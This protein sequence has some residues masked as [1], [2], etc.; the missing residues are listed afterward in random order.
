M[1]T[2][3]EHLLKHVPFTEVEH[4]VDAMAA[5]SEIE[6]RLGLDIDTPCFRLTRR[7]SLDKANIA[8][9]EPIHPGDEFKL[10]GCFPGPSLAV[11][12]A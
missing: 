6:R 1:L 12:V 10:T 7:T 5:D 2:A 11:S 3:S 8:R 9:V 4:S